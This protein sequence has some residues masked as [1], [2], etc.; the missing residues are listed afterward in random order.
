MA[1]EY[2]SPRGASDPF[3]HYRRRFKDRAALFSDCEL[4]VLEHDEQ[5]IG[6]VA[7]AIKSTQVARQ[8]CVI[9]YVF[10]LRVDVAYRRQG[11]GTFLVQKAEENALSRGAVGLYG[12]IVSVNLPSLK[13]FEQS[14]Y[15]RIRQVMYLEYTPAALDIPLI[16][17]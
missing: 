7:V 8:P 16:A 5:I 15:K 14:D 4:L 12:L 9:G 11:L 3:V 1:I 17:P 6:C 13:L 10:D 2:R